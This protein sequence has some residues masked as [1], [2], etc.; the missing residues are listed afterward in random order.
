M[1]KIYLLLLTVFLNVTFSSC[2]KED[3]TDVKNDAVQADDCCGEDG[4]IPPPPPPPI[5]PGW[6]G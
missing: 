5:N 2:T 1:K 3:L 6:K 4:D